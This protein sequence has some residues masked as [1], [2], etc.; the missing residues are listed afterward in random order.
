M[1]YPPEWFIHGKYC[2]K[3]MDT[4]AL[5]IFL[6]RLIQDKYPFDNKEEIVHKEVTYNN[7]KKMISYFCKEL[8]GL[9]LTKNP[10]HRIQLRNVPSHTWMNYFILL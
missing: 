7:S 4:W 2:G 1:M 5:G 9:L 6:Y 8:I 3:Q 10:A